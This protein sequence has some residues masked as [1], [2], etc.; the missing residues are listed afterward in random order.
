MHHHLLS[1]LQELT[2]VRLVAALRDERLGFPDPTDLR[3]FIPDIHLITEKRRKAGGFKYA[4]NHTA[5]LTDV[6][7][8]LRTLKKNAAETETVALYVLGDFL[9]LWRQT[10]VLDE[11]LDAAAAIRDD[12]EDLV[13]AAL[14]LRLKTRFLLGNHDS[15]LFRWP[16]Y[17]GWE[18]RYY[19]PDSTLQA[20]STILLHGDAFDWV[21][22]NLPDPLQQIM[23]YLFAPHRSA[24]SHDLGEMQRLI[25]KSH[26]KKQYK[27]ALHAPEPVQ[28]GTLARLEEI[29]EVPAR[30]NVQP[31]DGTDNPR[32]KFLTPAW[33]KTQEAN[34]AFQMNLRVMFIG[35]TH[36]ARIAL[37]ETDAGE[38][39][40]LVDCGAWIEQCAWVEDGGRL[41]SAPSAQIAALSGNEVRI[42]QLG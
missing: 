18:R 37:R 13:A 32:L 42:Y 16:D 25:K 33:E 38:F 40:A 17:V 28:L 2:D 7:D 3:V 19:L 26:G 5:L 1:A 11:R 39:F 24:N 23:V 22:S 12:H 4:T 31:N 35:H 14:D 9:D 10:P 21:E 29:D 15:D 8:A 20:P 34:R 30:W 41:Q 6:F 36:H 27:A